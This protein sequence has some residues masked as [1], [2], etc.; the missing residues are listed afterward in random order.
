[1]ARRATI[2]TAFAIEKYRR[3]QMQMPAS[4]GDLT[5]RYVE[6][7]PVDPL[8]GQELKFRRAEDA[9]LV[10]SVGR[11]GKDDAGRTYDDAEKKKGDRPE[12]DD[13]SVKV[14]R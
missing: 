5:P 7:I 13:V 14:A 3:N 1:M 11:N 2:T 8:S 4:L 9:V 10:Y 6:A 12:W